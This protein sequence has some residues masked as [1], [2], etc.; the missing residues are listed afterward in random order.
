MHGHPQSHSPL[1][2]AA[3]ETMAVARKARSPSMPHRS[4]R[5]CFG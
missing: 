2:A 5:T 1:H 3:R 4:C